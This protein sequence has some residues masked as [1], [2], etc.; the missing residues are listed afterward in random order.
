METK[1]NALNWN[2][3]TNFNELIEFLKQNIIISQ[4]EK[5]Y[6]TVIDLLN[7][8]FDLSFSKILSYAVR[9]DKTEIVKAKAK[10]I[11]IYINNAQEISIRKK[12]SQS[13]DK[14]MI[15]TISVIRR[16]I[17]DMQGEYGVLFP[18]EEKIEL[19][20]GDAI[21]YGFE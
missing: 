15:K 20:K 17:W 5:D 12:N 18:Y 1:I 4:I 10:K 16:L 14:I 19:D 9:I 7:I 2:A 11:R 8:D 3:G 13:Y 21:K 6:S